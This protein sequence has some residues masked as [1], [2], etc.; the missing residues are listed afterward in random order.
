MNQLLI[1]LQARSVAALQPTPFGC[2]ALC[3]TEIKPLMLFVK[4]FG[5]SF[6]GLCGLGLAIVVRPAEP[7]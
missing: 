3:A 5:S 1:A 6:S 2:C 4:S 7:V